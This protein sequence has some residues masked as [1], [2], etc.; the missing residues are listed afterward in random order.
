MV[1]LLPDF[2]L[3]A[4]L[5]EKESLHRF[6]SSE[7]FKNGL[8]QIFTGDGKGKTSAAVG[9]VLRAL[10]HGLRVCIVVFMK[11]DYPYSEWE[12]LSKLPNVNIA[13]FGS[14]NFIDPANIKPE[15]I[16]QAKQALAV[17]RES[18]LSGKYDL[19][20]LDEVNVA[21]AWKLIELDEVVRL[22][23]D[24]PQN[25]ELILTGRHADTKLVELADLVTECLKIKHPYDKGITSRKGI[26]Y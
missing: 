23:N 13:R 10:G 11:G 24:K 25:V 1:D 5:A 16:E 2:R 18:M 12:F 8:V 21:V 3:E 17:A 6:S 4:S 26:D 7:P 20:M 15:E 9:V 19:V 22:I 14:R